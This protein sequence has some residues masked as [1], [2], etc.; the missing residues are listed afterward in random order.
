MR[1]RCLEPL[2]GSRDRCALWGCRGLLAAPAQGLGE[3]FPGSDPCPAVS[4]AAVRVLAAP[5][6]V[7]ATGRSRWYYPHS[8]EHSTETLRHQKTVVSEPAEGRDV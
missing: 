4:A 5:V 3:A 1:A 6:P 7:L 2:C 8:H